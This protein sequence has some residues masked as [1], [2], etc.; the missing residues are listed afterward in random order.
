M[1]KWEQMET[2]FRKYS[3]FFLILV[4][5]LSVFFRL[6]Q[7]KSTPPALYP[8]EAMNGVNAVEALRSSPSDDGYQVFYPDN[9]GREGLYINIQAVALKYFGNEPWALRIVSSLFGILTVLGLYLLTKEMFGSEFIALFAAFFT[10]TSVWHIIFSRIGF[11][12]I[13]APAFLVWG[14]WLLWKVINN[15]RETEKRNKVFLFLA[16][17]AGFVFGLGFTPIL[18]TAPRQ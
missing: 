10:A 14:L 6:Y 4:L 1:I 17:I 3:I 16:I 18:P 7:I 12:A 9:N 15:E 8:D 13:M 11:R 5:A 2:F